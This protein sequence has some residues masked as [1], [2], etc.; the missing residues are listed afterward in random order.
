MSIAESVFLQPRARD[1]WSNRI[2]EGL[3]RGETPAFKE[4]DRGESIH[5]E[6]CSRTER[7]VIPFKKLPDIKSWSGGQLT[8]D[9]IAKGRTREMIKTRGR[10]GWISSEPGI[11]NTKHLNRLTVTCHN[12]PCTW[13]HH[14]NRRLCPRRCCATY[15]PVLWLRSTTFPGARR[16]TT[17]A[18]VIASGELNTAGA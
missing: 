14:F 3:C 2:F 10:T 9:R 1:L 6:I 8:Q 15:S 13:S 11:G 17:S 16:D 18:S 7:L 5:D 4:C 12:S